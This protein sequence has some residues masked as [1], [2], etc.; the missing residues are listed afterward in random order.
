MCLDYKMHTGSD[1]NQ[2]GFWILIR[3]SIAD[4][5]ISPAGKDLIGLA[6]TAFFAC[7]LSATTFAFH[8]E[9]QFRLLSGLRPWDRALCKVCS[10]VLI[11]MSIHLMFRLICNRITI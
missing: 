9:L 8:W 2:F 11:F 4:R 6:Q 5:L 3:F 7:V 10:G 1:R